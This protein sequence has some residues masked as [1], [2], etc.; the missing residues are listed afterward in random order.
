YSSGN[1]YQ[2][3]PE[4]TLRL[5]AEAGDQR[6][7]YWVEASTF[8]GANGKTLDELN[9]YMGRAENLPVYLPDEMRLIRAEVRARAGNLPEAIALINEVRKQCSAPVDEPVACLPPLTAG[10]LPTQSAVLQE[11]LRQRRY[12]LYLQGVR[13]SDLRR[14]G[15]PMAF[16]WLPLPNIECS[17]NPALGC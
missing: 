17:R 13:Y 5:E 7:D 10:D 4:Q 2:M 9:Q 3:R 16:E 14:F 12:E 6:V 15:Q 1:A 11:I 8:E